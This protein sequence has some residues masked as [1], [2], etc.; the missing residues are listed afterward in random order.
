MVI[1]ANFVFLGFLKHLGL[2]PGFNNNNNN[3]N[4][5]NLLRFSVHMESFC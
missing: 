3:N 1:S 2:S 5:N 4:D